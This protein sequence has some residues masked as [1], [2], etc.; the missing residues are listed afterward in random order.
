MSTYAI[1][2][3]QGCFGALQSLLDACG[4][5]QSRDRLLF[6]GDLVNRGTQS[7]EVLRFVKSLG[8]RALTVQGN[9]DLHLA[10]VAEGHGKRHKDDTLDAILT[11]P[12]RDE[13][14]AWL[15]A[16]PLLHVE[17]EYVVVHAG[18]LPQWSVARAQDLAGEVSRALTAPDYREFL[19]HMYGS[20][21]AS[22]DDRLA[23]W[24]QLWVIVNAPVLLPSA[25]LR[26]VLKYAGF[27]LG[28]I[29]SALPLPLKRRISMHRR[30]WDG[31]GA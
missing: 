7:L 26:T 31:A 15:R 29:E 1:G 9:H 20:E 22:W 11:A 2:D 21:P 18:L 4:F 3:V 12:D 27:S 25:L 16:Q 8:E 28:M 5:S 14:L 13:L 24:D 6:V 30:Y 23:G 17:G 10:M 19:A